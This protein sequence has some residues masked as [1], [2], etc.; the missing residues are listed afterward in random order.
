MSIAVEARNTREARE[1][2]GKIDELLKS[3]DA[4]MMM[5]FKEIALSGDGDPIVHEPQIE[6][7][8]RP[9]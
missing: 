3:S 6:G 4:R 7:F 2:A 5:Q 1:F 9:A 8:R